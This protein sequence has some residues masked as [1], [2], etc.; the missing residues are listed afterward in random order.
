MFYITI[1]TITP[2]F[3]P[4]MM[5]MSTFL[6]SYFP[7]FYGKT[8]REYEKLIVSLYHKRTNHEARSL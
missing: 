8:Y 4:K 3:M 6:L 5:L 2:C 7:T 1:N